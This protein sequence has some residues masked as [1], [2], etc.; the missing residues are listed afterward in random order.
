V[1]DARVAE[2]ILKP[3]AALRRRWRLYAALSGTVRLCVVIVF[4]ALLQLLLDR[5]LRFS[6][7]QRAVL[8][9]VLTG[10]WAW[11]AWRFVVS[12]LIGPLRDRD[13]AAVID[14]RHPELH[15][16]FS[17]AVQFAQGQVGDEQA[18]SPALVRAALAE[19]CADARNIRFE[20]ALNHRRAAQRGA[21]LG[22]LLAVVL[23]A[24]WLLPV[25]RI[26]FER[27]W[28]LADKP[29]P[30]D[31]YLIPAGFDADGRRRAPRG[32]E[33]EIVALIE[34]EVPRSADVVW[35]TA[36]GRK[37]RETMTLVGDRRFTAS[38]GALTEDV[39]FRLMGGDERTRRFTV[40]AVDRPHVTRLAARVTP[41][42]YTRVE[43]FDVEGQSYLTLLEGSSVELT[44]WT[45]KPVADAR[46]AGTDGQETAAR[47]VGD[48]RVVAT[49][50][51]PRTAAFRI[52]LT[53]RDGWSDR[54]PVRLTLK[55]EPDRAPAVKM[56]P[57]GVGDLVTPQALI[58]L[59]LTY[60][61]RYG[62]AAPE[63]LTQRNDEPPVGVPLEGF[64]PAM[65]EFKR[66]VQVDLPSL[67]ARAGERLRLWAQAADLYPEGPNVGASP[68]VE[69]RVVSRE[70]FLTELVLR[71]NALRQE[72]ERLVASQRIIKDS[73]ERIAAELPEAGSPSSPLVQRIAALSRRQNQHGRRCLAMSDQFAQLL[74]EMRTNRVATTREERRL[75]EGVI[76]PLIQLADSA[77]PA[78]AASMAELRASPNA[79]QRQ[80]A[81]LDQE[82]LLAAMRTILA[83][84]LKWEGYREAVELLRQII[85]EQ[86]DLRSATLEALEGQISDILDLEELPDDANKPPKP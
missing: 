66:D 9:A 72:F 62:L 59:S 71:E 34:N 6:L 1:V 22:G 53:D 54:N 3:L 37:G 26:W 55:V 56:E 47:V 79:Q 51:R 74:A 81:L 43:P 17:T 69:L 5:W 30:Q 58:G 63:L 65:R 83:G 32:D 73:L 15:D 75:T 67:G 80:S 84:M 23:L 78:A 13:L 14:A 24:F 10:L 8:D 35:E 52:E 18:N 25:M 19:A 57:R 42:A 27:N 41:P 7:D 4:A 39:T 20:R 70:D 64:D 21:E 60:E 2:G 28:L 38:L 61:D 86:A 85:G 50:E 12:V 77:M 48:D 11:C 36:S 40:I 46:L 44:A 68:Q 33:L 82:N 31:T 29:W 76:N 49:M 45:N 16:R